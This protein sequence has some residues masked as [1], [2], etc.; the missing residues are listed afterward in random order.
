MSLQY[1]SHSTKVILLNNYSHDP[2]L[3]KSFVGTQMKQPKVTLRFGALLHADIS[4]DKNMVCFNMFLWYLSSE[5]WWCLL[6][7]SIF[8]IKKK[9]CVEE[10]DCSIFSHT[11]F[12][13][14]AYA[15]APSVNYPLLLPVPSLSDPSPKLQPVDQRKELETW[16][17]WSVHRFY[18]MS[19]KE[20]LRTSGC[21]RGWRQGWRWPFLSPAEP[22]LELCLETW[23][24]VCGFIT[25]ALCWCECH[26]LMWM[27]W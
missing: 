16:N 27:M 7:I 3:H 23:T 5:V 15:T 18:E 2:S 4:A 20:L 14:Q 11:S 22:M 25:Q 26:L 24:H 13:K 9:A 1:F 21:C 6:I 19:E 12:W 17:V 10:K 8:L